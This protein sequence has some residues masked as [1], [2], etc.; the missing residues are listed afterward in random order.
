MKGECLCGSVQFSVNGELP[1]LYQCHCSLCRKTTGAASNA[2]TLVDAKQFQWL[3]GQD[4]IA[5]YSKPSGYRS[6]FCSHCGSPVP[7]MIN[8]DQQVW[9]PVG[10]LQDSTEVAVNVHLHMASAAR[11]ERDAESCQRLEAGPDSLAT[12]NRLLERKP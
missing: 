2:A 3:S 11:W 10:L 8:E 7:N 6:D 1:N 4:G 5:S 9:L 12:L